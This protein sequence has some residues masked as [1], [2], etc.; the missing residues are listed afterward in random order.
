MS[1]SGRKRWIIRNETAPGNYEALFETSRAIARTTMPRSRRRVLDGNCVAIIT[2]NAKVYCDNTSLSL[3]FIK[4]GTKSGVSAIY[5][6]LSS[7]VSSSYTCRIFIYEGYKRIGKRRWG[8]P[9][10]IANVRGRHGDVALDYKN[11]DFVDPRGDKYFRFVRTKERGLFS[12]SIPRLG[13]NDAWEEV[14]R[15]AKHLRGIRG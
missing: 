11:T 2:V 14:Q 12:P 5:R 15:R 4:V 8:K 9:V 7:Q 6:I 13:F 1:S 3:K 10:Q